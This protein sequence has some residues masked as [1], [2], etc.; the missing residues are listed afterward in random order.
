MVKLRQQGTNLP[1]PWF[2]NRQKRHPDAQANK[3]GLKKF[4]FFLPV[5]HALVK[6]HWIKG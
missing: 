1:E 4:S 6:N 5:N 3:P 2:S